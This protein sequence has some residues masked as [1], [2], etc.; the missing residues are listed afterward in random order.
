MK[1]SCS[2]FGENLNR[3]KT[4]SFKLCRKG[5]LIDD[6]LADRLLVRNPVTRSESINEDLC[7]AGSGSGTSQRIQLRCKFVRIV[8]KRVE[9]FPADDPR[10][11]V[12][13][14]IRAERSQVV[15]GY[16]LFFDRHRQ[17]KIAS[18]NAG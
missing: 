4:D 12:A 16:S 6:D 18:V 15:N 10:S 7:A 13:V 14:R 11:F 8:R 9:I 1:L 3:A 17:L 2:G 5:I